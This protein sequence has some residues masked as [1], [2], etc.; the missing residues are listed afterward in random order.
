MPLAIIAFILVMLVPL[1]GLGYPGHAA[2][3][4]LIFAIIMWASEAQ[5]LAVTSI[6]LLF[7]QPLLGVTS[8][9]NAVIGFANP[10]IFLMIGGF[11]LAVAIGKSGLAKR[12]TYWM[13]SKV[14]TTPN[15]SI[16]AAV[17]STGL[18][19]AWIE[20][21]VAFAMLLPIIKTIIP[22]F[23]ITEPEKGNSNFAKA[24]VLGASYGSLAG[25]FGTEIGTAPNLMAAAYTHLPFVNWMV[26]GFPLA[27]ILLLVTWKLLG[28]IFKP[29]V[30]GIVGGKETLNNAMN[31]MGSITKQEKIT[32][33]ILFFTIGLW[34]TTGI[35][36]LD[37]YSVALIG[38]AL[39]F[40]S[41]VI[42]WKDA[43]EGVDWGLII[44]F[45][46]ALSLGA[47][48]LNTGAATYIIHDLIGMMG[49]NVSTLAIMLLLMVIA[50]IFTQVMSNIA[51]AAILVP[52]SVTLAAAQGQP[53]GIYAVP[54]AISCSLSFMF[55][56]A[57][58]TVAMAYGTGYVKIK[59]ILKAGI[60]M[61]VIGII[62]TIAVLLTIGKP[63]LG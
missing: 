15:M 30:D 33:A 59:E 28:W 8:F 60:P 48:L 53:V 4:L 19:S 18:L 63:F 41:G 34:V 13:L 27:I 32:A 24:M 35:T 3:A 20:N 1:P 40:V 29:E 21:V 11:I 58:P 31:V 44:F 61:V 5:H 12:F 10:I 57:D 14:G 47:A 56:M 54:V 38:A 51:L 39:Y 37:S 6:M 36:G 46:G 17:F 43:Q 50:V 16:F 2:I 55:P 7:L 26:F 23:G 62:V 22:L 42:D 9:S 25:G 49:T 45:G 52:L